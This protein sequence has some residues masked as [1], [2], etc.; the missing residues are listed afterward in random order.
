MEI[1]EAH[2]HDS[3]TESVATESLGISEF[4]SVSASLTEG[5]LIFQFSLPLSYPI[6]LL[7]PHSLIN[8][9]NGK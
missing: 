2:A 7:T 9:Y 6:P 4:V 5:W 1:A 3:L 8:I